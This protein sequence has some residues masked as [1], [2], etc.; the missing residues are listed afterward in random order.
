MR[1]YVRRSADIDEEV[2]AE[3]YLA[4]EVHETVELVDIGLRDAFGNK[5]MARKRMD[6]IGF[7][8]FREK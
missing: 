8:R 6:A 4:R 5:I 7:V 2:D 1:D 3:D